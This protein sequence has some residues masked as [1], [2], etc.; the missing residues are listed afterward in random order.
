MSLVRGVFIVAAKRIPFGT[1]GGVLKAHSA[2]DMA[3]H[4]AKAALTAGNVAPEI[5]DS[6]IVGNVMQSSSDVPYIARHV[7]LRVGIPIPVPA[8]TVNRLCG[9]GFQ[10]II[11]G[12]QEICLKESEVVLCGGSESMSQS[13]YSVRNIRFGTKFGEDLKLE[14][15]LWA[16]LT[17]QHIK[18]P[19]GMTAEN[20]AVKYEL[21][22]EQCD[23]YAFRSQQRWKAA[24]DAGYFT[25]EM[26]PIEV[27][28]KKGK[29]PMTQDEHP[30]PQTTMEQMAKLQ[31]VFKKGGTVTAGNA[32]GVSDGAG[33][34]I[35]AS[36][37]AVRKH[38][39][40]PL[41][42]IVAY[43]VSGCDPSIMGIGPVPAITE[44]LKKAG[45]YLKDMD[46]VEVNEAFAPQYLAVEKALGLDPEKTNVNGGAIALG[47]P[48]GASGSRI[49]A[50]L[51]HEL[52]RR[53]GKYAV[54]SACIGGGQ[55]IAVIIENTQ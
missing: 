14:D 24:Q 53:N 42:R 47:H 36:E 10:S 28:T 11:N 13:P 31:P 20:L 34:V 22:K 4:A 6:V 40:K 29:Q 39:L 49:T 21:S 45:L 12:A 52:R 17:D 51:V 3:A 50:H 55:G 19:M 32:S 16:G 37:E 1:Y 43:H 41:A 15:T 23:Q 8:L 25:A 2:T 18:T 44:A 35:V 46:L 30:R 7:G 38:G 54:G 27:Q 9:S 5:V 33:A 48:L 26:A